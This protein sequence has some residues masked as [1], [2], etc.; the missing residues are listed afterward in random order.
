[1]QG[2]EFL[3]ELGGFELLVDGER[4]CEDPVFKLRQC[5]SFAASCVA[6][7]VD[8]AVVVDGSFARQF[9]AGESGLLVVGSSV[10]EEVGL[11]V[12]PPVLDVELLNFFACV[13]LGLI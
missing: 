11:D 3:D 7:R 6:S 10:E 9:L 1:M 2:V 12:F 13:L 4:S 5:G 8:E